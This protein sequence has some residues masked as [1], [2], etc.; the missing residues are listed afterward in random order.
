M[1]SV[2]TKTAEE[3]LEDLAEALQIPPERYEAA[4]RSYKSVGRW[5]S[6]DGSTLQAADPQVYI[7]GSF[8]L[9]TAIRPA[10]EAED[11][12]VDLVCE[13]GFDK[14][15]ITQAELKALIGHELKAYAEA[16]RMDE[17]EPGHR[18]WTLNY[19]EGAQFHLDTLPALPDGIAQRRLLEARALS[20]AWADTAIA[21]TD[22]RHPN[23]RV[24]A[25]D[26][27][28]SNPKGYGA[29]FVSRM[30]ALFE[31]RRAALA[32]EAHARVEDIPEYRV[33]TPL[34]AAVQILKRHRDMTFEGNPDD[35]PISI[36]LTTLAAQAY[37]QEPTIAGALYSIL[38]RMDQFIE[39]R[40]GVA[41]IANPTDP[42]ENF[43]DKWLIYPQRKKA[44]HAWLSAARADFAAAASASAPK[45]LVAI[46]AP[47]LGRKL[48]E[49]A[50]SR[51]RG[52]APRFAAAVQHVG[53]AARRFL[54]PKWRQPPPWTPAAGGNV[55]IQSATVSTPGFRPREFASGG[56]A[57]PKHSGLTFQASTDI[58]E[59][60]RIYWQVVNTGDEANAAGALRGG[61]DEGIVE[62]GKLTRR[63]STLYTGTHSIECF[64]VKNNLL[65]ARSGQFIVNIQ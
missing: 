9:G 53:A 32:L 31:Q 65:V 64:I 33:K 55:A 50:R 5:L 27:L 38:A 45:D 12:D 35:K 47:R 22:D 11:Y 21:I 15:Q 48:V 3:F 23:F 57:L 61:F 59:P 39:D 14:A 26:W 41:W 43:A 8:R 49:S 52:L 36:I 17:P 6:R 58:P 10:S 7:Q 18:C 1:S 20:A 51:R 63:E 56:P 46:L 25:A 54:D 16:H 34:Q 40:K 30:K 44:F 29:W 24:R 37:T 60:Y 42:L 19:A 62:R 4:E 2:P 28:H 13:V